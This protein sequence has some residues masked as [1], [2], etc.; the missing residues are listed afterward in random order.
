MTKSLVA[1]AASQQIQ[2]YLRIRYN[3]DQKHDNN[4]DFGYPDHLTFHHFYRMYERNSIAYAGVVHA[5]QK[6]WRESPFLLES[7]R[8]IPHEETTTERLIREMIERLSMWQ[9]LSEADERSRV[10][11]YAGILLRFADGKRWDEPVTQRVPGGMDGLVELI[12]AWEGQLEPSTYDTNVMSLTYGHPTMYLFNEANVNPD[13]RM[14]RAFQVHPDRVHIWSKDGSVHGQ[15]VLEPGFNDLIVIEKVVGSGGEGFWQNAKNAPM[16]SFDKDVNAQ[17]IAA[18][19][20]VDSVE[21]IADKLD[22]VVAGWREGFDKVL[23]MQGLTAQTLGV[24]LPQPEEFVMAPLRNFAATIS[25][26]L[27]ILIGTQT[28]ERASTEDAK[29]WD[30]TIMS[31]RENY[32]KPNIRRLLRHLARVG[33]LPAIEWTIDWKDLTED[34]TEEK[35]NKALKMAEV[36]KAMLGIGRVFS[37]D[38]IRE[39]MGMEPLGDDDALTEDDP[40]A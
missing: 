38:E 7:K 1:N 5:I 37:E 24:V 11:E 15:S 40:V 16:L 6:T 12:P 18:M 25:E 26:P 9:K 17:T 4:Y 36:N 27:K 34:S 28:G 19:L 23:A 35:L 13:D 30:S 8:D 2:Q 14:N 32:V 20:G 33:V 39:A 22:E 31:R 21:E 3:A 10:G 29:E